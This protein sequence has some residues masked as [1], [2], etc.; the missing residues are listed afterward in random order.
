M[1]ISTS[2]ACA[3]ASSVARNTTLAAS[4]SWSASP[5]CIF[6]YRPK[7]VAISVSIVKAPYTLRNNNS[8]LYKSTNIVCSHL[9]TSALSPDSANSPIFS[10]KTSELLFSSGTIWKINTL[11]T[12]YTQCVTSHP[13]SFIFIP[14]KDGVRACLPVFHVSP[15]ATTRPGEI[16]NAFGE[17]LGEP[18]Y[19]EMVIS[20][21]SQNTL[22]I[23]PLSLKLSNSFTMISFANST[24]VI[25]TFGQA[26]M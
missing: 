8:D 24:S 25:A 3:D 19:R 15:E 16:P 14:E 5:L 18:C 6:T 4:V 20:R 12:C 17:R 10:S 7:A 9:N 21:F 23:I 26:P 13:T 2:G 11:H 22:T 1:A